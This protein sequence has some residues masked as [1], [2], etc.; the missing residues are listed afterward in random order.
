[1][2]QFIGKSKVTKLNAKAGLVYPLISL[3]LA[4]T[5]LGRSQRYLRLSTMTDGHFLSLSIKG[6][7]ILKLCDRTQKL[8]NFRLKLYNSTPEVG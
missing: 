2:M 7:E 8:Y 3:R 6:Q 5:K 1:M 4:A